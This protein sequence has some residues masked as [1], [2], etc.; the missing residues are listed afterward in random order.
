MTK[1]IFTAFR[2]ITV[3]FNKTNGTTVISDKLS[4]DFW[5][6]RSLLSIFLRTVLCY[7]R[8][9]YHSFRSFQ[10][11]LLCCNCVSTE[12]CQRRC[13]ITKIP[14]HAQIL[15]VHHILTNF[16]IFKHSSYFSN[17]YLYLFNS[18]IY[19][20]RKFID[21]NKMDRNRC[22]KHSSHNLLEA[23]IF[24]ISNDE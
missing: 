18:Q 4:H 1:D 23:K 3:I 8:T 5:R 11:W 17:L 21:P 22:Y 7:I 19:I 9:N 20:R 13:Q 10:F 6:I 12:I 15:D 16:S 2:T 24:L 14:R